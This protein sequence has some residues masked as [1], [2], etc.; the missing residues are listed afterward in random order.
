MWDAVRVVQVDSLVPRLGS[1][2]GPPLLGLVLVLVLGL[3]L[4]LGRQRWPVRRVGGFGEVLR[5]AD[6][7]GVMLRGLLEHGRH[8][9]RHS[10]GGLFARQRGAQ[11]LLVRLVLSRRRL[12]RRA[13]PGAEPRQVVDGR[14]GEH[15]CWFLTSE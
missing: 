2:S 13:G 8:A 15:C 4:R 1:C 3:S 11:V 5:V 9:Q 12:A 10:R 7:G 14:R 6:V